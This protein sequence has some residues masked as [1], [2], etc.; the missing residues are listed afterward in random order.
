LV[1]ETGNPADTERF[2]P[3]L[4]RHIAL[5]GRPPRQATADGLRNAPTISTQPR[6][7]A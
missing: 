2:L 1:I 6:P 5:Y 3:M 4:D 7:E